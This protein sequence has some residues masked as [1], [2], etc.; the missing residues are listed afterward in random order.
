MA[1]KEIISTEDP[2]F[3]EIDECSKQTGISERKLRAD[4][5]KG[6]PHY[7]MGYRTLK[8]KKKEVV[9]YYNQ[10]RHIKNSR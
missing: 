10:F 7:R 3:L 2:E 4:L 5:K 6:L 8:F 9:E 1:K